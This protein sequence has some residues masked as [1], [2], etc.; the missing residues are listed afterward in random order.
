M[1]ISTILFTLAVTSSAAHAGG[2]AVGQQNA[3]SAGTGG[4]GAARDDDPGAAWHDPAALA[5]GGGMRLGISLALAHPTLQARGADG[6]W[7]TDSANAW[8]TPPHID[9]SLAHDK[10]AVGMALGV[11]FGGGVTWPRPWPGATQAVG[12]DLMVLRA[13]PFAAYRLGPVRVAGGM[14]FDAGRLQIQRDLD[15]IDMNGDVRIDLA[16]QGVG[17]DASLYYQPRADVSIGLVYRSHTTITFDG[18]ANFT[19]PDAFSEKTPDQTAQTA[20]TLPAQVVLGTRWKHG[21]LTALGDLEYTR[22]SVN[23]RTEVDFAAEAT[24]TVIQMNDWHNTVTIRAGAEWQRDELTARVGGYY[25]P[26][27]VPAEHLTPTAPDGSRVAFTAGAGY[28]ISPAWSADAFAEQM[29]ILRRDTTSVDTMPASYGGTAVVFG[30][31][32]RWTPAGTTERH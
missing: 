22:W 18:N 21:N 7:T 32:V 5:D 6:T 2:T 24:P 28:R 1:K 30:L 27:P 3:V 15:F 16:G 25:D 23:E 17:V 14:H 4:A 29:W 10:W 13:A 8:A 31:G 12:T 20:M 11:P 19:A 26:S 9:A